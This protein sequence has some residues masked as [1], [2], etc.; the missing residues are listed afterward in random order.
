[1]RLSDFS[2]RAVGIC[3]AAFF[4]GCGGTQSSTRAVP[5]SAQTTAQASGSYGDLLYVTSVPY[6][7]I[8]SYPEGKV[9]P[10]ISGNYGNSEVCS[11]PNDGNVFVVNGLNVDEYAHGG[12]TPIATLTPPPG[13]EL[14]GCA[15]DATTDNLAVLTYQQGGP[16]G[17]LIWVNAQGYPTWYHDKQFS[18]WGGGFVYDGS[19]NLFLNGNNVHERFRLVELQ[20]G[21]SDFKL[22]QYP[23]GTFDFAI[24]PPAMQWDGT[25]LVF[26]ENEYSGYGNVLYQ[27]QVTGHKS[28]IVNTLHL[29]RQSMDREFVLR[30]GLLF[31]F[32]KHERNFSN[33]AIAVWHYPKAGRPFDHFYGVKNG[34]YGNWPQLTLSVAPSRSRIH[35]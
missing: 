21:H 17:V 24:F 8:L 27:L 30:D 4:V 1:M 15:V 20:A 32:Y 26:Q 11:D 34:H 5:Q 33:Y 10:R 7:T 3:A 25:Y 16:S 6:L 19:G 18:S 12:T 28:K 23:Q 22:I 13:Q 31:G 29:L 9:V 14:D 2:R 35:R